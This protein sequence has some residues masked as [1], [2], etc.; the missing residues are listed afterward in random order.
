MDE[1][2]KKLCSGWYSLGNIIEQTKQNSGTSRKIARKPQLILK[3]FLSMLKEPSY[4]HSCKN[5]NRPQKMNSIL[6]GRICHSV[7]SP[8]WQDSSGSQ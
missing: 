5:L 3:M 1:K 7:E 2:G 6:R 8:L 4:A